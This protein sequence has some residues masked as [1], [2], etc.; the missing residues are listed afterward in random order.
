MLFIL[1]LCYVGLARKSVM[2]SCYFA[3]YIF[4]CMLE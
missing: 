4:F 2:F 3:P 1:R